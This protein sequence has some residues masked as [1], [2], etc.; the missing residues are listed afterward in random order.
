MSHIQ[1]CLTLESYILLMYFVASFTLDWEGSEE[2][3]CKDD[4]TRYLY[5][6]MFTSKGV[7]EPAI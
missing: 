2:V 1:V 5:E 6:I 3:I 4:E 7:V